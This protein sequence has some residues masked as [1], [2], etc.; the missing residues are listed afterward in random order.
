MQIFLSANL[1]INIR[2]LFKINIFLVSKFKKNL[3]ASLFLFE[4]YIK[5]LKKDLSVVMNIKEMEKL[6]K[7]IYF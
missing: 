7:F 5:I 1:K 2:I 6:I 3:R 4:Y